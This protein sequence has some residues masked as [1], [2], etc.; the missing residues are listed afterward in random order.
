MG[1]FTALKGL[2]CSLQKVT[3]GRGSGVAK[4]QNLWKPATHDAALIFIS[5]LSQQ[6]QRLIFETCIG[7]LTATAL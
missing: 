5:R 6:Y 1:K 2:L 3:G 4:V 7:F